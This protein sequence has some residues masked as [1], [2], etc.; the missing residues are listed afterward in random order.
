MELRLGYKGMLHLRP[1][2]LH[3]LKWSMKWLMCQVMTTIVFKVK[4]RWK[5][6][7]KWLMC[8]VMTTIVFKVKK[9]WKWP[10][11]WLWIKVMKK[12]KNHF[13]YRSRCYLGTTPLCPLYLRIKMV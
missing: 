1:R 7:M 3:L 2:L 4:K 8:Q 11:K 9:R 5:W 13:L 10:M 6:P 12:L